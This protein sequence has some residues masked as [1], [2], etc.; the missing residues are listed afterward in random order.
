MVSSAPDGAAS[1][2][3]GAAADSGADGKGDASAPAAAG[4]PSDSGIDADKVRWTIQY[5]LRD[6]AAL[7]AY[8]RDHAQPLIREG[9]AR[10]G[11]RFSATRRVLELR[12]AE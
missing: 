7:E 1:R 3:G 12:E 9:Q 6:R 4:P 11:D 5:R 2:D 10:F 8:Q